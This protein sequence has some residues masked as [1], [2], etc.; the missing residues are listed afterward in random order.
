MCEYYFKHFTLTCLILTVPPF[1]QL[2][3]WGTW[4]FPGGP[5]AKFPGGPV[6]QWLSAPDTGGLGSIPG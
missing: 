3:N 4:A 2:K 5:V 6:V 1:L